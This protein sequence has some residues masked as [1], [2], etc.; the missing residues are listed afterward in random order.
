[1]PSLQALGLVKKILVH[2]AKFEA[3]PIK[4]AT[5][6]LFDCKKKQISDISARIMRLQDLKT[7]AEI[8]KPQ[9]SEVTSVLVGKERIL[10]LLES[11]MKETQ[12]SLSVVTPHHDFYEWMYA[13][14]NLL[15]KLA[16]K[17]VAIRFIIAGRNPEKY[18]EKTSDFLEGDNCV[19]VSSQT[20]LRVCLAIF[21][22]SEVMVGTSVEV[23]FGE[24]PCYLSNI[25]TLVALCKFYFEE[26][27]KTIKNCD[28]ENRDAP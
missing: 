24:A 25:P 3:T 19:I 23:P 22:D 18:A 14:R 7:E 8:K 17:K 1:M 16:Q 12:R 20:H 10:R 21:D 4:Q 26:C 27:Y 28:R 15:K 13:H 5:D 11:K 9:K 6:I 2:P